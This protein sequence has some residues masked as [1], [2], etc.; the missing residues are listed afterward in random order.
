MK[1]L[2][3]PLLAL[4]IVGL[5]AVPS[6]YAARGSAAEPVPGQGDKEVLRSKN[7]RAYVGGGHRSGK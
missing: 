7:G 5:V 3:F 1:R 2:H 6:W 4:V